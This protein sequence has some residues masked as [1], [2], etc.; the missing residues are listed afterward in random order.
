MSDYALHYLALRTENGIELFGKLGESWERSCS[1]GSIEASARW[2]TG[3]EA[4][5][6]MLVVDLHEVGEYSCD[7]TRDDVEVTDERYRMI[8]ANEQGRYRCSAPG[9]SRDGI[10]PGARPGPLPEGEALRA[11]LVCPPR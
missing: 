1:V 2:S 9:S 4:T 8:C 6:P 3:G 10:H 11:L 5:T 7:D